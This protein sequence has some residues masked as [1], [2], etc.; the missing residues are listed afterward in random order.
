[1]SM[2]SDAPLLSIGEFSRMTFLSVKTLRHYH[3]TRLLEPAWI[4]PSSGYRYYE[5]TQVTTAQVIR[6]FRDL[7]LPIDNYGDFR[8]DRL[9]ENS[10]AYAVEI[11]ASGRPA[12]TVAAT[13]GQ[14]INLGEIRL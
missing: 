10:G 3:E 6:R 11:A 8:F 12:K 13:L 2:T 4:D 7:D 5:V 1:M 9:A 14:S